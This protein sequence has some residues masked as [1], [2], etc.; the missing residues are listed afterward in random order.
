[1]DGIKTAEQ[2]H[3]NP[4]GI[5]TQVKVEKEEKVERVEKFVEKKQLEQKVK[6]SDENDHFKEVIDKFDKDA[7]DSNIQFRIE[8]DNGKTIIEITDKN[9]GE[10]LRTIPNKEALRIAQNIEDYLENHNDKGLAIDDKI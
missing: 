5:L 6:N 3:V 10:V 7:N 1:M 4:S 8:K 2:V 9:T